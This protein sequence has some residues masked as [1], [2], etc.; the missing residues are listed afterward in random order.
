[1]ACIFIKSPR[2]RRRLCFSF[3][4]CCCDFSFH[5]LCDLCISFTLTKITSSCKFI[6]LHWRNQETERLKKKS[7]RRIE[8][9]ILISVLIIYLVVFAWYDYIR[10]IDF[11]FLSS[12]LQ[13]FCK[14]YIQN[15]GWLLF[16]FCITD[17]QR[18]IKCRRFNDFDVGAAFGI[19][20]AW[21]P[22]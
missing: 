11:F 12:Q 2:L 15:F 22:R 5:F 16:D 14:S 3:C 10:C 1:M 18:F 9:F 21:C 19:E 17:F 6:F 20:Y 13:I 8:E 4:C 7:N